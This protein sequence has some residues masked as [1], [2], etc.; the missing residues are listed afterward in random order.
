[1]WLEKRWTDGNS[2]GTGFPVN[3]VTVVDHL[4]DPVVSL[5]TFKTKTT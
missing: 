4:D 1:M 2:S 5:G 3:E